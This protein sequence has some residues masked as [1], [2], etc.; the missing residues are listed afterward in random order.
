MAYYQVV[1]VIR[2]IFAS[3]LDGTKSGNS[4]EW[5]TAAG[6][7]RVERGRVGGGDMGDCSR[8]A[9]KDKRQQGVGGNSRGGGL[10]WV[11]CPC[12]TSSYVETYLPTKEMILSMSK[13]F[14]GPFNPEGGARMNGILLL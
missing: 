5:E 2:D 7:G 4:K 3:L 13:V 12:S 1:K 6:S 11:E 9:L 8:K 14:G 10:L